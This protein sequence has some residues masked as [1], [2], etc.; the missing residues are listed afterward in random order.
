M[1]GIAKPSTT[2][3]HCSF[4]GGS[5]LIVLIRSNIERHHQGRS[6]TLRRLQGTQEYNNCCPGRAVLI[7]QGRVMWARESSDSSFHSS[8]FTSTV[9][10]LQRARLFSHLAISCTGKYLIFPNSFFSARI[11][12]GFDVFDLA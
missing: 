3:A 9:S 12:L 4:F 8:S 11:F 2:S 5:F 6:V 7:L 1:Q 10:Q